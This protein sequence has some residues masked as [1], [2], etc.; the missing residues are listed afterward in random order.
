RAEAGAGSLGTPAQDAGQF[1]R[2]DLD[3]AQDFQSQPVAFLDE[4][5][6]EVCGADRVAFGS[7]RLD[8][9]GDQ[10]AYAAGELAQVFEGATEVVGA[11]GLVHRGHAPY[12]LFEG[13]LADRGNGDA[14]FLD[15]LRQLVGEV[16]VDLRHDH[17]TPLG[18]Y[19]ITPP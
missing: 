10:Y 4:G 3:R 19:V 6:E 14:G 11:D 15:R 17:R 8:R 2:V 7:G 9:H 16:D 5:G 1:L 18:G 12:G 13:A